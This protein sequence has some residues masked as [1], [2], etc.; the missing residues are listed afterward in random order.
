MKSLSLMSFWFLYE[1]RKHR[2]RN[3]DVFRFQQLWV[4]FY[5][6]LFFVC[7]SMFGGC[8]YLS[9]IASRETIL[10]SWLIGGIIVVYWYIE[11]ENVKG[12]GGSCRSQCGQSL[13]WG[14]FLMWSC[15]PLKDGL[16]PLL[17]VGNRQ[18]EIRVVYWAS[19]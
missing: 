11:G 2:L 5:S 4:L 16:H 18:Q 10:L 9:V 17:P 1:S 13:L 12:R 15:G 7:L 8:Y 19:N 14:I 3:R 6:N